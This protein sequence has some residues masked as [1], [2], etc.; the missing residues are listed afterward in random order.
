MKGEH[1]LPQEKQRT[2]IIILKNNIVLISIGED[3]GGKKM[4]FDSFPNGGVGLS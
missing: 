2:G 3:F 4:G 1:T